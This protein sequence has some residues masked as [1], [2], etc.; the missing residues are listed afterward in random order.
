LVNSCPDS[1]LLIGEI[2]LIGGARQRFAPK[3]GRRRAKRKRSRVEA[4]QFNKKFD[5][6][7]FEANILGSELEN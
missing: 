4:Q 6:L 7:T 2:R 3:I 5:N 1:R